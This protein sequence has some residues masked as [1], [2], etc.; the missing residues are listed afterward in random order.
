M[1]HYYLLLNFLL[2]M[3]DVEDVS[4]IFI[5]LVRRSLQLSEYSVTESSVTFAFSDL[6]GNRLEGCEFDSHYDWPWYD[7]RFWPLLDQ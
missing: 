3:F 1:A 6:S 5:S 4:Y 2:H 7:F